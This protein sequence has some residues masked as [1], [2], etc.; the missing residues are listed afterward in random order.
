MIEHLTRSR[1]LRWAYAAAL[2]PL[3][4]PLFLRALAC[5]RE[6]DWLGTTAYA[7]AIPAGWFQLSVLAA[8]TWTS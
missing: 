5:H 3:T 7:L 8:A 6:R 2:G 1:P 4:G